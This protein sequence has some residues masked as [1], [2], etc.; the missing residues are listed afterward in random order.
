M[1]KYNYLDISLL[2]NQNFLAVKLSEYLS[3][4]ELE[5][6]NL[7]NVIVANSKR[8]ISK[9]N[10]IIYDLELES[11]S[12]QILDIFL[13]DI[14]PIVRFID[15]RILQGDYFQ[16]DFKLKYSKKIILY[17]NI[18]LA[19]AKNYIRYKFTHENSLIKG[20][21][22]GNY[23]SILADSLSMNGLEELRFVS[24][25]ITTDENVFA[26]PSY[27]FNFSIEKINFKL[28]AISNILKCE[29]IK[30]NKSNII[31]FV[32]DKIG[33]SQLGLIVEKAIKIKSKK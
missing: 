25:Y 16:M 14:Y 8:D 9:P 31:Y 1:N 6:I 28:S 22:I 33:L 20:S 3:L 17:L 27:K 29:F 18:V 30:D 21:I 7:S 2:K 4:N 15:I 11:K 23:S 10:N 13:L 5:N 12:V 32:R 24:E 26:D 19:K